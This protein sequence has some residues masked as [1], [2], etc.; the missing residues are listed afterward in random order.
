MYFRLSRL[1]LLLVLLPLVEIGILVWI[2]YETTWTLPL[3]LVLGTGLAGTWILR[4]QGWPTAEDFRVHSIAGR[5]PAELLLD[6]FF[7]LL[8]GILLIVPGVLSDLAAMLLLVP[9]TRRLIKRYLS[10]WLGQRM[11]GSFRAFSASGVGRHD[12]I[13]EAHVIESP[14]RKL[15]SKGGD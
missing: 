12:E 14:A 8:A 1:W 3:G 9:L 7:V 5:V 4:R 11:V 2:G 10:Y 13:I 15:E 6:R